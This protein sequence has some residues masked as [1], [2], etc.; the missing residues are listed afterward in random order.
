MLGE[1]IFPVKGLGALEAVK[2]RLFMGLL[3]TSQMLLSPECFLTKRAL[4]TVHSSRATPWGNRG[5]TRGLRG[6]STELLRQYLVSISS[7]MATNDEIISHLLMTAP[8]GQMSLV[9]TDGL[10]D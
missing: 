3:V 8:T 4:E 10:M 9:W 5:Q 6:V 2:L 7:A 1:A